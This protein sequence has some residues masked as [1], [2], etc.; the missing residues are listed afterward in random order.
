MKHIFLKTALCAA[1]GITMIGCGGNGSSSTKTAAAKPDFKLQLLHFADMDSSETQFMGNV[2]NFSA[3]LNALRNEH[4]NNTLVLSSG[5]NFIPGPRFAAAEN[6]KF[7][8]TEV[9]VAG[10]GRADIAILNAMGVQASAVGNHDLDAGTEDFAKLISAQGGWAGATFPYLSQNLDFSTDKNVKTLIKDSGQDLSTLGSGALSGFGTLMVDGEKIGIIG[11]STPTLNEITSTGGIT[12]NGKGD[13]KALAAAIQPAA[14]ALMASGVNKIIL[15]AHMQT[16]S[17]EKAL[18]KELNGVDII[19]A[20]GSNTLLADANDTLRKGDKA[21]DTYPLEFTSP[22]DEPVLVVNTDADFK[23]LGRLLVGFDKDGK[24]LKDTLDDKVNGAYA[25]TSDMAKKLKGMPTAAISSIKTA[26]NLVLAEL[27]G[28]IA[29]K[30]SVYLEGLR[31]GVRTE[32]T[33]LGNLTADANLWLAR[34]YDPSV[35]VSIKNGGGIRDKIGTAVV[36]AGGTTGDLTTG[37]TEANPLIGKQ[38]G[39]ISQLDIQGALRFNNSLTLLDVSAQELYNILE[40]GVARVEDFK[41]QFPQ[42]AGLR[43][44]FDPTKP[45]RKTDANNQVT[46]KGARVRSLAL[47]DDAGKVTDIIV[48]DGKLQGDATR[49]IRIVTLGFLASDNGGIG[50]DGYPFTFPLKNKLELKKEAIKGPNAATFSDAGREQ[51]ALA[52]YLLANHASSA[53]T[54]ADTP[55]AGD[56]RIQNLSARSDTVFSTPTAQARYTYGY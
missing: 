21:A 48:K 17:T 5:D 27:D 38:A 32:E 55:K 24:I 33:N 37:P 42:V 49:S 2:E 15:L 53:Y 1:L 12:V 8:L 51:D 3:I 10:K 29:G 40:H 54:Y 9:R 22:S 18:A 13:I 46:Q 19:V 23:Y 56:L 39:D 52:E 4:P 14:D 26:L 36:P 45:A 35:Q 47:V 31:G 30:S 50:G 25:A 41:G 7:N 11:A 34:Q 28:N 43:F 44:S 20:G 16:I 6:S